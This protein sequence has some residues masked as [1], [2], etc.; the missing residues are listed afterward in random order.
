VL[1]LGE[2][3]DRPV[4]GRAC[5][6][7]RD[8]LA[9]REDAEATVVGG[10]QGPELGHSLDGAQCAQL[11]ETEVLGE[12][13][14]GQLAVDFL[15]GAAVGELRPPGDVGGEGE[16]ALVA[17]DEDAVPAD[18]HVRLDQLGPEVDRQLVAGRRVLRAVG[19]GASVADD[20]GLG[21]A[22]RWSQRQRLD[23][24]HVPHNT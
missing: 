22:G 16:L 14:G 17:D 12:P 2:H 20:D 4:V 18:H 1:E 10:V 19:R 5:P 7:Q 13:A 11:G 23:R 3:P 24:S 15:G 21:R 6:R 8:D 9:E